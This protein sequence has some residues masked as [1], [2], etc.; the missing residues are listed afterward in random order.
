VIFIVEGKK[1]WALCQD[2]R[3][4]SEVYGQL[5]MMSIVVIAFSTIG[6]TVFSDDGAMKPEHIPHTDLQE[7]INTST[8]NIQIVHS[9]GE[10]IDRSAIKVILSIKIPGESELRHPEFSGPKLHFDP[11]DNIFALGDC[12]IIDT[13]NA[14]N[15]NETNPLDDGLKINN[16]YAIDMFFVDTPSQQVI[17]KAVLQGGFGEVPTW[18][19]PHPYGSVYSDSGVN[20]GWQST[21]SVADI[22][23]LHTDS[24]IPQST[25]V[26]EN[27]TF[28]IDADE[29]GISNSFTRIMLRIIYQVKNNSPNTLKLSIFNGTRWIQISPNNVQTKMPEYHSIEESVI[30]NPPNEYTGETTYDITQHIKNTKELEKL[31]VSFSV[32]G[33][34]DEHSEKSVW[35][36][37]VGIHVVQ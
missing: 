6:A 21:E 13:T 36:D 7:N 24:Q 22:D 25:Y 18:I 29:M 28:G 11:D 15:K 10:A 31:E 5:L 9:G 32:E 17:Q 16:S 20:G 14:D 27:Y 33:N 4:V 37:F 34:A 8:N 26:T 3:G 35:V 19:T 30:A 2:C 12:I 1:H 23:Q